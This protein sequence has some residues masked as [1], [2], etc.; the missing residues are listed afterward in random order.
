MIEKIMR[1]QIISIFEIK[2]VSIKNEQLEKMEEDYNVAK[3][4]EIIINFS[5]TIKYLV[6]DRKPNTNYDSLD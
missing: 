3:N 1:E 2:K 6:G 4:K 5:E